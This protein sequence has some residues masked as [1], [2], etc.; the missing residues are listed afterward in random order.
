[1]HLTRTAIK[2]ET[3]LVKQELARRSLL[4]F[5][6]YTMPEYQVNW[7]HERMAEQLDKFS[8]GKLN[9]L[10]MFMPPQTGKTELG[11]RRLVSKLIGD[12]PDL[13]IAVLSY[14]STTAQTFNREIKRILE[15]SEYKALYPHIKLSN[16][17]DG[18]INT[19]DE[20]EIVGYKG[21]VTTTGVGGSLTSKKVDIVIIDDLY[22]DPMSAW[23]PTV[24]ATVQEWYYGVVLARLHN[25]SQQ[26][27]IFT[28]WHEEDL[29]G[30][31]LENQ[32]DWH[33]IKFQGLKV[34]EPTEFDPRKDGEAL[35]ESMHSAER[36]L[37][38]KRDNIIIFESLY[39][40][41]P[42]PKEGLLF[43]RDDLK[44]FKLEQLQSSPDAVISAVDIADE[45]DDS[46]SAPIAYVYDKDLYITDVLFTKDTVEITQPLLASK[47]DKHKVNQAQFESNA[48]GKMYAIAVR[49]LLTGRTNIK[50]KPTTTNK[51]TRILL[52]SGQVKSNVYFLVDEE[53]NKEYQQF[54]KELTGYAK[55]G[56][57][58]H[59]DAADSVTM[60]IEMIEDRQMPKARAGKLNYNYF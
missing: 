54:F 49:D 17:R 42:T 6:L 52:K 51:P 10:M 8:K 11:T 35:W 47:L 55:S 27:V 7:H 33:V 30:H 38:I 37:N 44:R 2:N 5:T 57:N 39:Q 50:W 25:N 12:N 40:Q 41:E 48:G 43:P 13:K 20:F 14:N 22:K 16:G 21:K 18:Y 60:L 4:D 32:D 36:Y 58:A 28:R 15:S 45:G 19:S 53:Q 46:L 23:S 3:E 56:K 59:D 24:R 34:G 31:I 1:M 9:K 26:L 29:A